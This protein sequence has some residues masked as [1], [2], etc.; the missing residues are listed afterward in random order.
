MGPEKA[1]WGNHLKFP[2]LNIMNTNMYQMSHPV[3]KESSL[4]L[5]SRLLW[6]AAARPSLSLALC[7]IRSTSDILL[8]SVE[9]L[10]NA[11]GIIRIALDH[12]KNW[13]IPKMNDFW[14][15]FGLMSFTPKHLLSRLKTYFHG[16]FTPVHGYFT[17][18]SSSKTSRFISQYF[19]RAGNWPAWFSMWKHS[20]ANPGALFQW[21]QVDDKHFFCSNFHF[22]LGNHPQSHPGRPSA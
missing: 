4:F 22:Y 16:L 1:G 14:A 18:A 6:T 2:K 7:R 15:V 11:C 10:W 3:L 12:C 21:A 20:V 19:H 5:A 8:D 9:H 17:L 13:N